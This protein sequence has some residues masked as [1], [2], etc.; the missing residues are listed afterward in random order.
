MKNVK[1]RMVMF[2]EISRYF[3]DSIEKGKVREN[4]RINGLYICICKFF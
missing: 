1:E 3:I 2:E 4:R